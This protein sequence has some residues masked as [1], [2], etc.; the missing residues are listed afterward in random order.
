MQLLVRAQAPSF[1]DPLIH[2]WEDLR[3]TSWF[4]VDMSLQWGPESHHYDSKSSEH[5]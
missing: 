2:W 5:Q 1:C 3:G 4:A